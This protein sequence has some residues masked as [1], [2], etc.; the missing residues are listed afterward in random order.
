SGRRLY[1]RDLRNDKSLRPDAGA[2]YLN[3]T[4]PHALSQVLSGALYSVLRK[5]YA[6]VWEAARK[7]NP[8]KKPVALSGAALF[9]ASERF[10]RMVLRALDYLPPGEASFAD[11]GRAI[12]A[13]DT[14]SYPNPRDA[15][16]RGWFRD[17]FVKR[18]FVR[19]EAEF[20]VT[21]PAEDR[22]A[23]E[24]SLK[25]VDLGV[26]VSSDW[27]AYEFANRNRKWL[28]IP[29]G[30]PFPAPPPRGGTKRQ[31]PPTKHAAA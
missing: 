21:I 6:S 3:S 1:L 10:K 4:E 19:D 17:E 13:S 14:A 12:L 16:A 29:A 7:R 26:L 8:G 23:I 20:D 9:A 5:I 25:E 31:L 22:A 15:V 18:G 11:L 30:V 28:G 27:A 24:S 2:N